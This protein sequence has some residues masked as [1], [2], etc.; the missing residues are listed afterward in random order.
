MSSAELKAD[1]EKMQSEIIKKQIALKNIT[2]MEFDQYDEL[3]NVTYK[4]E[5]SIKYSNTEFW[6]ILVNDGYGIRN[7]II[8][9]DKKT[10]REVASQYAKHIYK[11]YD[12][13]K[14]THGC[15]F[16]ENGSF[17]TITKMCVPESGKYIDMGT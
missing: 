5:N 4:P 10:V 6:H 2:N 9:I 13:S 7:S 16:F 8:C 17:I 1:I 12:S 15:N 3:H 11:E 14:L